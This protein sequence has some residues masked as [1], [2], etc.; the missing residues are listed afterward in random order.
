MFFD[1]ICIYF[2]S[3]SS[4]SEKSRKIV[5]SFDAGLQVRGDVFIKCYHK[6]S[7][8]LAR[9]TIFQLQFHTCTIESDHL[10]FDKHELDCANTG[11]VLSK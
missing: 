10:T 3:I 8:P 7:R 5:V 6:S 11:K 2:S 4:A 1:Y 9:Y